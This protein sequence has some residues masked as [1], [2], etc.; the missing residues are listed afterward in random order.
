M[1]VLYKYQVHINIDLYNIIKI[2]ID[3]VPTDFYRSDLTNYWTS[4]IIIYILW[5]EK[6]FLWLILNHYPS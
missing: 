6:Y 4:I 3:K 5:T 2:N 1:T